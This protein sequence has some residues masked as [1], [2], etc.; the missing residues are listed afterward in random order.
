[1]IENWFILNYPNSRAEYPIRNASKKGNT[2]FA[3]LVFFDE[4][5]MLKS[6]NSFSG[7]YEIKPSGVLNSS[8]A[9]DAAKHQR[10]RYIHHFSKSRRGGQARAGLYWKPKQQYIGMWPDDPTQ[11][12]VVSS[13]YEEISD[14]N[15]LVFYWCRRTG[16]SDPINTTSPDVETGD[17]VENE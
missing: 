8:S 4:S 9:L 15:G 6:M 5:R 2:G 13:Y 11:E 17:T 1:M 3:D 10:N 14:L 16:S 7:I 12:L